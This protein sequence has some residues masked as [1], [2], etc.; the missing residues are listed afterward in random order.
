M[1]VPSANSRWIRVIEEEVVRKKINQKHPIGAIRSIIPRQRSQSGHV[2]S[3]EIIGIKGSVTLT[4]EHEIR[5]SLV[6]GNLR[7]T[8]FVVFTEPGVL[9]AKR[10][11]FW[12]GGWGHG[13]GMCQSGAAG[14]ENGDDQ[15]TPFQFT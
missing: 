12:G 13:V 11:I 5:N 2:N 14:I 9:S 3:V 15:C 8:L 10:F 4:K 7:S 1:H 6:P